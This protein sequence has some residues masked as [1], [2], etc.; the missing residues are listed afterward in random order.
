MKGRSNYL[1]LHRLQHVAEAPGRAGALRPRRPRRRRARGVPAG[2][3]GVGGHDDDRRSRRAARS[4]RGPAAVGPDLRRRRD[5]PGRGMPAVRRVFRDA[6]AAA[7]GGIRRGDREPPP[8]VRRRRGAARLVRRGDP[9]LPDAGRGRSAPARGRGHATTSA[10][11]SATTGWTSWCATANGC[12]SARTRRRRRND[13]GQW[14]R[15]R[16]RT[17]ARALARVAEHSRRFFDEIGV[18]RVA[19][20]PR[21]RRH[22]SATPRHRCR[23]RS[24]RGSR[25]PARSKAWRPRWRWRSRP[26]RRPTRISRRRPKRSDAARASCTRTFASLLRGDDPDL[27]YALEIRGP[28]RVPAGVAGGR[29]PP[30]ARGRVRSLPHGGADLGHA[31]RGRLASTT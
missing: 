31:G 14:T 13:D 9:G 6:D 22:A 3:L 20:R 30:G 15:G 23:S 16:S 28:R 4:A 11:P 26:R 27:V 2:D 21:P 17:L 24:N 5:V 1:C 7:R 25:W 19:E 8:P 12:W 10:S 29:V 18:A